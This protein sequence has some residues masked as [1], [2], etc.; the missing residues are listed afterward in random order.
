VRWILDDGPFGHL[1]SIKPGLTSSWQ[2]GVLL[3]AETTAQSMRSAKQ[4][5]REL[6]D[7]LLGLGST[8]AP[9]IGRFEV[10]YQPG[11]EA[12]EAFLGLHSVPGAAANLAEHES[13][14]WAQTIGLDAVFVCVAHAFDLWIDLFYREWLTHVEFETLCRMT[15]KHDQGGLPRLPERVAKLL[16]NVEPA[17]AADD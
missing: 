7:A 14:A 3:V 4:S 11:N 1:A 5:V 9:T 10:Q 13:I 12:W 2:A 17:A 6:S 15:R 8:S 16:G